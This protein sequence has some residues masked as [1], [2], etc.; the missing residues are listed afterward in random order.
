MASL[1]SKEP[2]RPSFSL[3]ASLAVS[4]SWRPSLTIITL[5]VRLMMHHQLFCSPHFWSTFITPHLLYLQCLCN[6]KDFLE[7]NQGTSAG[8]IAQITAAVDTMAKDKSFLVVDGVG[9]PAV[10]SVVGVSNVEVARASRAPV[11]V[12]GKCGVGGAIDAYSLNRYEA[13][14]CVR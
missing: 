7:G 6:A 3:K 2:T 11:V 8:W 1:T 4:L 13:T 14:S 10:G 12:V 5:T 9:F